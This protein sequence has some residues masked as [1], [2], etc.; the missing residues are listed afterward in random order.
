MRSNILPW[1]SILS[2]KKTKWRADLPVGIACP[3]PPAV[4]PI[5]KG[6]GWAISYKRLSKAYA[7]AKREGKK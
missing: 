7:Y 2:R 4:E 1:S 6:R 5:F 3:F